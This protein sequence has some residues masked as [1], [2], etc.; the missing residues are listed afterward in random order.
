M[1]F[2]VIIP[3]YNHAHFLDECLAS[4]IGQSFTDWE[5]IIVNDGSIDNTIEVANK[6]CNIDA[7]IKLFSIS[8]CGLSS[9]RNKGIELSTGE[10]ISLLDAD[11]KYASNHLESISKLFHGNVDIVF[12]GYSYFSANPSINHK[13]TLN[14]ETD[15][16]QILYHNIAPPVAVAFNRNLLLQSGNFDTSLK[17]AEDWDLWIRF[18]KVG[19]ILGISEE[20][21]CFYRISENSMS[22]Q[23]ITMYEALKQVSMQACT[24][25]CRISLDYS[26][27][28]RIDTNIND[29]IKRHLFLCLGVAIVQKKQ[30]LAI[31]LF[32]K[33]AE[34]FNFIFNYSD[35][36]LLCS[37]L[38]FRYQVSRKDIDW[39]F[40]ILYPLFSN[41]IDNI[42]IKGLD[43]TI[44]MKEIFSVHKKKKVKNTWGLLSPLINRISC[45]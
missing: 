39:V 5:A 2:S 26:L 14:V 45:N 18:Y 15:F 13:V 32:N 3:C 36:K 7:R 41:F 27:N 38:S 8:N 25:D 4:L 9:A 16:H 33:E 31:D 43:K 22:R 35:F 6:W 20:S 1:T 40:N 21:S 34:N 42:N 17:S 28:K 24:I 11:D 30:S 44:L 12:T 29:T 10:F 37:H 23:F 19:A